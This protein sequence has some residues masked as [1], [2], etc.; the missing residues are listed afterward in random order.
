MNE[1]DITINGV[2]LTQGQAMTIRVALQNYAHDLKAPD[3]LGG[4]V[5]GRAIASGYLKNISS[6]NEII[7]LKP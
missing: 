5:C 2:K 6:I 1:P 7:A 4:D 3:A